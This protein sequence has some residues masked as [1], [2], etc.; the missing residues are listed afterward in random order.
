[1]GI[2]MGGVHLLVGI[3]PIWNIAAFCAGMAGLLVA[4]PLARRWRNEGS[5]QSKEAD[6]KK[7]SDSLDRRALVVAE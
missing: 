4:Y 3:S 6:N 5:S 7:D 2:V 1:M